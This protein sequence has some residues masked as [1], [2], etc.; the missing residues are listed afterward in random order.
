MGLSPAFRAYT[1]DGP[2]SMGSDMS[3]TGGTETKR[4]N[5]RARSR[6]GATLKPPRRRFGR[7]LPVEWF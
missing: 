7:F 5:A 2:M 6:I 3:I 1:A 4:R